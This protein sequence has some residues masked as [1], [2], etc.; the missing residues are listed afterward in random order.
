MLEAMAF[1]LPL[2]VCQ[3]G[4]PGA[5]VD[6]SCAF[7]LDADSPE[8]LA[9]DCA[10]ALRRLVEDPALRLRMGAAARARAA[11]THLWEHRVDQ[12]ARLYAEVAG[13]APVAR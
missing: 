3:R 11:S 13:V 9:A 8:Q 2:V 7:R 5:N 10:V 12:M 6:D 4:G 1:G